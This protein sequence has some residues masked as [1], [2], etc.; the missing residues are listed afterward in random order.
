MANICE[1][2]NPKINDENWLQIFYFAIFL[3][4]AKCRWVDLALLIMKKKGL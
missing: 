2:N 4:D 1:E 3:L